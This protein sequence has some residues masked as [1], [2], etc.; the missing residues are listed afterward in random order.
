MSDESVQ[1]R[2]LI[3]DKAYDVFALRGYRNVTMKDIVEACEIS[4]GGLYLYFSSTEEIFL[5]VLEREESKKEETITDAQLKSLSNGELLLLFLKEQ[6]KEILRKK[7][8]LTVA[9]YE[10]AFL[11]REEKK[12]APFRKQFETE[13]LV[14]EKILEKGNISGEFD[15]ENPHE[16][17]GNMMLAI[18]GMKLCARTMGISENRVDREFMHM[19]KKFVVED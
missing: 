15:C 6:K 12:A 13:A 14:L 9:K 5:A 16:E 19:M 2:N 8:S 1:K 10:Y 18:E 17:A 11:C 4:R 3:I 7:N